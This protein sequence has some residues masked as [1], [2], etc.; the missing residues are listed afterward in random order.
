MPSLIHVAFRANKELCEIPTNVVFMNWIVE[1][2]VNVV[3]LFSWWRTL[4]LSKPK[5]IKKSIQNEIKC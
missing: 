4:S 3:E 1:N 2:S 5:S